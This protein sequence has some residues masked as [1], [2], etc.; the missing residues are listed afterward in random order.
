MGASSACSANVDCQSMLCD[1]GAAFNVY[2]CASAEA[3]IYPLA[4]TPFIHDAGPG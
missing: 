1:P 4:C 2:S 3:L